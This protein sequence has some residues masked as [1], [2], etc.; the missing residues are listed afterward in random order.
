M[1]ERVTWAGIIAVCMATAFPVLA[2]ASDG[3]NGRRPQINYMTECQGC[4]LPDGAG[5]PGRVPSLKGHIQNFLKVDGGRAYLV[6][7]P[8]SAN[9]RLSDADLADVLNWIIAT[10]GPVDASHFKPYSRSEVATYRAQRLRDVVEKRAAL[11]AM[12]EKPSR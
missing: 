5:M 10:M 9:S 8:G 2:A 4:H 1:V 11:V 7:V 12:M 3:R 6:Q